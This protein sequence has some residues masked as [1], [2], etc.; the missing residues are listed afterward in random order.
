M[1]LESKLFKVTTGIVALW[2]W[3]LMLSAL[4]ILTYLAYTAVFNIWGKL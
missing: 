2:L 1:N 3:S 4:I